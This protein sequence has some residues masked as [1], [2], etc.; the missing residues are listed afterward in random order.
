MMLSVELEPPD[1]PDFHAWYD[2][3]HFQ[4]LAV[5]PGYRRSARYQMG[6]RNEYTT[7]DRVAKFTA[8]HYFDS[9]H[10]FSLPVGRATSETPW[11]VKILTTSP[12]MVARGWDLISSGSQTLDN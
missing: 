8:H 10:G 11:T 2:Q 7:R 12:I 3:E 9:L 6:P 5:V 1:E 4:M